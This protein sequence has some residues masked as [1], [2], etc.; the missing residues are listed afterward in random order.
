M[1]AIRFQSHSIEARLRDLVE[2][3]AALR[4]LAIAVAEMRAPEV[5]YELVAK[6]AADVAG[7]AAGAVVR[8]RVDGMGEVVGSWRMGSRYTGSL[9]PLDGATG[10]AI[11]RRSG[12]PARVETVEAVV[13]KETDVPELPASVTSPGGVAVPIRV[14]RELWG[15]LLVVASPEGHIPADLEERLAT[16]A[17]LVG[18]AITKTDTSAR[19]LAGD[20]RSADRS[21]QPPRVPGAG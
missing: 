9:V 7:V 13:A 18:L 19:L 14:R 12:R 3:Q 21:A 10:V 20:E 11:V 2:Q 16:F 5:I 1:E 6:Q 8:F 4:E 17:D 15:S